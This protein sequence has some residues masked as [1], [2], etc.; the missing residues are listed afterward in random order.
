MNLAR[1]RG[2]QRGPGVQSHRDGVDRPTVEVGGDPAGLS[3]DEKRPREI[4][5]SHWGG[6]HLEGDPAGRGV[7]E[8]EGRRAELPNLFRVRE[9]RCGSLARLDTERGIELDQWDR[10]AVKGR[11]RRAERLTPAKRA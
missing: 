8:V 7:T 2:Q 4:E 1:Q 5:R 10:A 9:D 3:E 6:R 11:R